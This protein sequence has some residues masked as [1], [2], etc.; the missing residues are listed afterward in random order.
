MPA[1][2]DELRDEVSKLVREYFADECE[3]DLGRI[4]DDTKIIEEL[5]GDSLMYLS[6]LEMVKKKYNVQVEIKAIGKKLMAQPVDTIGQVT[7]MV[8]RFIEGM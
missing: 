8:L 4:T 5:D 7:D 3:V 6:L 1:V 2:T